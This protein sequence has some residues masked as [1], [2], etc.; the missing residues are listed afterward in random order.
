LQDLVSGF[1]GPSPLIDLD[2]DCTKCNAK[3]QSK[4][5][6]F[7]NIRLTHLPEFLI[8]TYKPAEYM[9]NEKGEKEL[10]LNTLPL[11]I[12]E[13]LDLSE[14]SEDKDNAQFELVSL[15]CHRSQRVGSKTKYVP[16]PAKRGHYVTYR[17]HR[18]RWFLCD[19]ENISLMKKKEFLE[20]NNTAVMF[21]YKKC[22]SI[23]PNHAKINESS[24]TISA[25]VEE[26]ASK[27]KEEDSQ[28]SKKNN[29]RKRSMTQW[30]Y[31][32]STKA[33]ELGLKAKWDGFDSSKRAVYN[34][35]HLNYYRDVFVKSYK[36]NQD[37]STGKCEHK[38]D[39][40]KRFWDDFQK[41]LE[42]W[43]QQH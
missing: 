37:K 15:I 6:S 28:K 17:K 42:I 36:C 20:K 25:S 41:Y 43:S 33:K 32:L 14:F 8:L 31:F 27:N 4:S 11:D 10:I 7:S 30:S 21:A 19:D 34:K 40:G 26:A 23:F 39:E 16:I 29:K 12:N 38:S 3:F 22:T 1:L 18:E 2:C 24:K 13:R 35:T 5:S 9:T